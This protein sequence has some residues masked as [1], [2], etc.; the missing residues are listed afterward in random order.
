MDVEGA[1]WGVFK[2]MQETLKRFPQLILVMEVNVGRDGPAKSRDFYTEIS[3]AFPR[4]GQI[5]AFFSRPQTFHFLSCRRTLLRIGGIGNDTGVLVPVTLD[6]LLTTEGDV[7]LFLTNR[8]RDPR[9]SEELV[10]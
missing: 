6:E 3:M 5:I 7:M 9:E 4:S 10:L 8:E 2:G 1:E